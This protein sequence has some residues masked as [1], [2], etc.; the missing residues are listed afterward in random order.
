VKE[1]DV[2]DASDLND[3]AVREDAAAF[4]RSMHEKERL[5]RAQDTRKNSLGAEKI[6]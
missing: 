2:G 1:K 5:K 3:I 6:C 4:Y